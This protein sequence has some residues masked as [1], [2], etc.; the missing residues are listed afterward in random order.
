MVNIKWFEINVALRIFVN[1]LG[2]QM[3]L[4]LGSV[5]LMGS[6]CLGEE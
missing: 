4:V 5:S 1:I 3:K 2:F 6:A